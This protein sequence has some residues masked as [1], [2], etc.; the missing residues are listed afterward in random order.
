[1]ELV[2]VLYLHSAANS[3][4]LIETMLLFTVIDVNP[5][6]HKHFAY[7]GEFTFYMYD[8]AYKIYFIYATVIVMNI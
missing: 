4:D 2:T 8:I 3:L 7:S 1:M 6:D 5:P